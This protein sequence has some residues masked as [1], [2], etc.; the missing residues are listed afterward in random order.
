MNLW[1]VHSLGW[2][3]DLKQGDVVE[4]KDIALRKT[5]G[6]KQTENFT[7]QFFGS[8]SLKGSYLLSSLHVLLTCCFPKSE[9]GIKTQFH[10][11]ISSDYLKF[12][13]ESAGFKFC[14]KWLT[15]SGR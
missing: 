7:S 8:S 12:M 9:A 14:Q 13:A 6:V 4:N 2:S 10:L 1:H 5:T 15:W 3:N 11:K